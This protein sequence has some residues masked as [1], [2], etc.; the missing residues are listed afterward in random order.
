MGWN[1]SKSKFCDALFILSIA[2][3]I[4]SLGVILGLEFDCNRKRQ[5]RICLL[6]YEYKLH[7]LSYLVLVV[8]TS[9]CRRKKKCSNEEHFCFEKDK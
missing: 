3:L 4:D 9:L 1:Y 6:R 8:N 2:F 7:H 5:K